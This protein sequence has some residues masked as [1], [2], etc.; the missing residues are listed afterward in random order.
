MAE[1]GPIDQPASYR[2]WTEDRVRFADL[3]PLGHCNNAAI[4]GFFESSRVG[5]LEDVGLG[6]AATGFITPMAR[7]AITFRSE[8]FYGTQVRIGVRVAKIGR[9]SL[10][11]EAAI[12]TDKGSCAA[13]GDFVL[14]LMDAATRATTPIPDEARARLADYR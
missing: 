2:H 6:M 4:S 1:A 11:L 7:A 5:L 3:D 8:L 12:F 9:T 14:V 10:T 13:D